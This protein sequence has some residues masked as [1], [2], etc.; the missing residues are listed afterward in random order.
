[1][2]IA[3]PEVLYRSMRGLD[4]AGARRHAAACNAAMLRGDITTLRRAQYFLAQVASETNDLDTFVEYGRGR[5]KS[6]YP[7]YG[8]GAIQLTWASNYRRFGRWCKEGGLVD[9]SETFVRHPDRVAEPKWG[10]LAAIFY[11]QHPSSG[12]PLNYWCDRGDFRELT[13]RINGAATWGYPSHYGQRLARL[14]YVKRLGRKVLPERPDPLAILTAGERK[15]VEG[16]EAERRRAAR[17]GWGS[18]QNRRSPKAKATA[19]KAKIRGYYMPRLRALG[20]LGENGHIRNR[21][22]RY[23]LLKEAHGGF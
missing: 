10:W 15:A 19:W 17:E 14:A 12:P 5:G 18:L 21:R 2:S 20:A 11:W 23:D 4:R 22:A 6:Y 3:D 16:L 7:Y 1:M 9:D 8:R 13:R